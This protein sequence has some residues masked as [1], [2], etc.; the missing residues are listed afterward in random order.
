MV[1]IPDLDPT[2]E[3]QEKATQFIPW[4]PNPKTCEECGAVCEPTTAFV[5]QQALIMPIY[6]C[7]DCGQRY[8]R[9]EENPLTADMW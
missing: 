6:E 2:D 8:F 1:D 7:P 9:E 4:L 3:I 5:E